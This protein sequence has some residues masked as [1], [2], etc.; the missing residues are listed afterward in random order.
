[1]PYLVKLSLESQWL[2]VIVKCSLAFLFLSSGLGKVIDVEAGYM[3]M[4]AA[5]LTP[6]WFFNYASALILLVGAYC[7]LFERHMWLGS[8]LLSI[9]LLLTIF[10]VHTFWTMSGL[11]ATIAFYF[12]IEHIAVIGGL[13]S[14]TIASH[15]RQQLRSHGVIA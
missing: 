10:I 15:F 9:F 12:A 6:V 13:W 14:I 4:Q 1:M 5:G 8:L 11:Q 3:E 2:W 7:I